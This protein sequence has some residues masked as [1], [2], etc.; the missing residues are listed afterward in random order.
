MLGGIEVT[1]RA[2][3]HARD[4]LPAPRSRR[5]SAPTPR[6]RRR[7]PQ[8]PP[9]MTRRATRSASRARPPRAAARGAP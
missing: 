4:M 8:R 2:R 1:G 7:A 5:A 6:A 3:E 9:R